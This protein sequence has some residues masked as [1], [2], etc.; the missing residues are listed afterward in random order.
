M[1]TV[2]LIGADGAGKSTIAR[3][4]KESF[5]LPIKYLYMGINVESSNVALPSSRFIQFLKRKRQSEAVTSRHPIISSDIMQ[6]PEHKRRG[7]L[8]AA[9]RLIYRLS[10]EWYRQLISWSYQLRGY[11]VIYDRHF[12]F[13]FDS[14]DLDIKELGEPLSKRLHRW[15]LSHFYPRPSL[16]LFLD[17][18]PE[19]LYARK[20]EGTLSYLEVR[21][22]AFSRQGEK[23]PNFIRIDA[24]Q[25]LETVY[26]EVNEHVVQFHRNYC[27]KNPFLKERT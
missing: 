22:N 15:I 3:M 10:E 23:I 12:T 2:A 24:S 26:R 16:V 4:L 25:P 1:F 6:P 7:R 11:I 5:Q 20:G 19:V 27:R 21:R 14:H 9:A 13:D 18:S 8:R 17:A